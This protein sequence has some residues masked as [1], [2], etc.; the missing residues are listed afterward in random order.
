MLGLSFADSACQISEG[1]NLVPHTDLADSIEK[2]LARTDVCPWLSVAV[3]ET[4]SDRELSILWI[5]SGVPDRFES[6][7]SVFIASSRLSHIAEHNDWFDSFRT[8]TCRMDRE[9]T[10]LLTGEGTT[11]DRF[12]RR[13]GDLFGISVVSIAKGPKAVDKRWFFKSLKSAEPDKPGKSDADVYNGFV[14]RLNAT[15][16]NSTPNNST[17]DQ[18]ALDPILIQIADEVRVLSVRKNGNVDKAI[19]ARCSRLE[20]PNVFLLDSKSETNPDSLRRLYDA[21]CHRWILFG[22]ENDDQLPELEFRVPKV[23]E[24]PNGEFLIHCTRGTTNAWPDQQESEYLDELIFQHARRDH[25]LDG[26]LTR[27][28]ATGRIHA[29]NRMTRDKQNVVC[30]TSATIAELKKMTK[31]RSHLKRWDFQPVGIAIR[32]SA[33]KQQG[34]RPVI[35]GDETTWENLPATDRPFFQIAKSTTRTGNVLDWTVEKEWRVIGD[36]ELGEFKVGDIFAIS[37][38]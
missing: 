30:F 15:P 31:F 19:S 2:N 9:R 17:P 5:P 34:A 4:A 24:L 16:N 12:V 22:Q 25:S 1:G 8:L 33:L 23:D 10:F 20:N 18:K 6:K 36:V 11:A 27:I 28:L 26:A 3:H 38:T 7:R 29:G 35:Y 21:G 37:A 14:F 32:K 13:A